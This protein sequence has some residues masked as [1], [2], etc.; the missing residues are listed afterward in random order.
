MI[1]L[2]FLYLRHLL[3]AQSRYGV[4]SPFV[5]EFVTQVLPHRKSS[6]GSRI[7]ALRKSRLGSEKQLEILDLGAGYGGRHEQLLH[8]T[9]AEVLRS[10]ARKR[11]NG[12][13]L[14]RICQWHQPGVGL[15]L[16]TNLGYSTAYQVAG[17]QEGRGRGSFSEVA[18]RSDGQSRFISIEGSPALSEEAA[19]LLRSLDLSADLLVGEFSEQLE[20]LKQENIRFDY[21][22]MDGNHQYDPTIA[23]F[24]ALLDRMNPNGL[25]I[26]DDINWSPGMRLAWQELKA[27][28]EVQVTIDLFFMGLCFV[29][30]AQAKEDFRFRLYP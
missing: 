30:R 20:L 6:W 1:Q 24:N 16:G 28:E 17:Q 25:I 12:E 19:G 10:S 13:L 15:E 14:Y 22:L 9:E 8:K 26:V 29:H 5:Y 3:R 2:A 23:Y 27:R 4:H 11:R 18:G 21:V 7:D